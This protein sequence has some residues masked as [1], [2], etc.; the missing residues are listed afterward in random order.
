MMTLYEDF[1]AVLTKRLKSAYRTGELVNAP[2]WVNDLTH[3]TAL[4]VA[5]V[6]EEDFAGLRKFAHEKLDEWIDEVRAERPGRGK[7]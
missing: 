4:V 1:E 5:L 7:T 2:D 6:E 3:A